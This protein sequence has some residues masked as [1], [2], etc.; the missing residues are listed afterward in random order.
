MTIRTGDPAVGFS[1]PAKPGEDVDVGQYIGE[2]VVVL[3]F[4]PLAFSSVCAAEMRTL[5]DSWDRW[6]SLGARVFGISVDSPFV[7]ERFRQAE[8]VPFPLL[9]DF[10]REVSSLYGVLYE[11]FYGLKGVSKRSVFV[12][13]RTG[14][15]VYAWITDDADVEPGYEEVE[16]A[17]RSA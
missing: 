16:A 1:L 6:S 17:V 2:D 8:N 10:N 14:T 9:S 7:T 5:G 13:D 3:V 12:I 4:F 11:D 15:V